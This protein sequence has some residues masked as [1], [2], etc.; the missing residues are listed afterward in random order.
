MQTFKLKVAAEVKKHFTI[1]GQTIKAE[2]VPQ[3]WFL[4]CLNISGTMA[5]NGHPLFCN[6]FKDKSTKHHVTYSM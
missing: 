5:A 1:A 4:S 3:D 6:E 2:R